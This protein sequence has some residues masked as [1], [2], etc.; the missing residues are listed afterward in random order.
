MFYQFKLWTFYV[1]IGLKFIQQLF[2]S[3]LRNHY[4]YYANI[5]YKNLHNCRKHNLKRLFGAENIS[6]KTHS[7]FQI[8]FRYIYLGG[9]ID[10]LQSRG[11]FARPIIPL[12][13]EPRG[14]FWTPTA[15]AARS[16]LDSYGSTL[17]MD[18]KLPGFNVS[19]TLLDTSPPLYLT[20]H[21][22]VTVLWREPS[23]SSC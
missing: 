11:H 19:M 1:E 3:N 15:R 21:R 9:W 7:E 4:Y 22:I 23:S 10:S 2:K 12:R 6:Y 5:I 14:P 18:F 13:L 16:I 8:S 20:S 17:E